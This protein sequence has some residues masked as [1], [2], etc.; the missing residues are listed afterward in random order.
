MIDCANPQRQ[1]W[2]QIVPHAI[3]DHDLSARDFPM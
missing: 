3:D 2:R 1:L